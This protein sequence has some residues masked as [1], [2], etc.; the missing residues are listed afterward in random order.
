MKYTRYDLNRKSGKDGKMLL[1]LTLIVLV[2]LGIGTILAKLIF[3]G[4]NGD[5]NIDIAKPT[6]IA[7][8]ESKEDTA[9]YTMLQCGFYSKK[10]NADELKNKLKDKYN[11]IILQD[12][13]K[14]R[15]AT[16]I[17][18][19]DEATK[20][21]DKLNQESV[22]STKISYKIDKKDS[23]NSQ[24]A[25]MVNGYLQIFNKIQEKDVKSVKTDE[26]KKWTNTLKDEKNS[27]NYKIFEE[28]KKDINELPNEITKAD[29]DKGYANIFKILNNFKSK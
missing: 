21:I 2:A 22:T 5:K 15:V 26:F 8:V 28:F 9:I 13:D 7:S 1:I 12:G 20:V 19:V 14:F 25:G 16:F 29:L 27:A 24:I 17:G 10:E 18:S 11:A 4:N 6:S 3:T 23:A